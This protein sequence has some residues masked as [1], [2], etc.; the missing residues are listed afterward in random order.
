MR[1]ITPYVSSI[2]KRG[3]TVVPSRLRK[4][5]GMQEGDRLVWELRGSNI[6]VRKLTLEKEEA[7][8]SLSQEEW[9]KL[10]ALIQ[11]QEQEGKYTVYPSPRAAKAHLRKL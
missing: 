5:L 2:S 8:L 10:E 1:K 4:S 11:K 9:K 6:Y 7:E 3:Q